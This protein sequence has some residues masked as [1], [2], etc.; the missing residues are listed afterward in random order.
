MCTEPEETKG[1]YEKG[2]NEFA[3]F[4]DA[5]VMADVQE[6]NFEPS[7]FEQLPYLTSNPPVVDDLLTIFEGDTITTINATAEL[8][9]AVLTHEGCV[10]PA[11]GQVDQ[12]TADRLLSKLR[13]SG[14]PMLPLDIGDDIYLSPSMFSQALGTVYHKLTMQCFPGDENAQGSVPGGFFSASC[15]DAYGR[16]TPSHLGSFSHFSPLFDITTSTNIT[17]CHGTACQQAAQAVLAYQ[18]R[19]MHSN[20]RRRADNALLSLPT[21][22]DARHD[23]R[24]WLRRRYSV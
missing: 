18:V 9:H 23:L 10:N 19:G 1:D 17:A 6:C 2:Y 8:A 15:R 5:D 22:A 7:R 21:H 14:L 24:F 13:A 11:T 16:P 4:M 12:E 20:D 3:A